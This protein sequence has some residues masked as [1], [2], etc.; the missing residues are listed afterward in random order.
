MARR[1]WFITGVNSGFGRH[2]A[3]RLL[4]RVDHVAGTVRKMD[5]M[6]DLK[7]RYGE[8][9]WLAHLDVTATPAIHQVVNKAFPD[10]GKIDVLVN[11]AGYGL[12]GA[13]EEL[14]EDQ[15]LHQIS[16]NLIGSI[17]MVRAALPHL[18][19]QGGGRILQFST[20]G[21]QATFPG[22]FCMREWM[23]LLKHAHAPNSR[24]HSTDGNP[25][26]AALDLPSRWI[27]LYSA[28]PA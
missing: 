25:Q 23:P 13:A 22:A 7:A 24:L 9:L 5:A 19:E 4:A 1:N 8:A 26:C 17:Q 28:R 27:G 2:M 10:F 20:M 16:T 15:I 3:E 11:N 21:G 12:F 14:T 18:R 6:K